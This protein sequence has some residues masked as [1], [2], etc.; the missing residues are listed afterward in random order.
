MKP[1][2]D[3]R[4][5]ISGTTAD[6]WPIGGVRN[7]DKGDG[8]TFEISEHLSHLGES[9]IKADSLVID[10]QPDC[11]ASSGKSLFAQFVQETVFAG[12]RQKIWLSR[13]L[14]ALYE[15]VHEATTGRIVLFFHVA[16]RSGVQFGATELM[17]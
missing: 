13:Q 12:D 2:G 5:T 14:C 1:I 16:G 7:H 17:Q 4:T 9:C 11:F 8:I 10:T 3:L 15:F 6:D